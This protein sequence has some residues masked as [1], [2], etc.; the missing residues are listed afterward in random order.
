MPTH[1]TIVA[2]ISA[3]NEEDIIGQVVRALIADGVQVYFIDH[4][5]TDRTLDEVSPYRGRGVIGIERFP[6]DHDGKDQEMIG[7]FA[8]EDILR[9]KETLARELNADWFI[10]HDADEFRESPWPGLSLTEAIH[11]LTQQPAERIGLRNRGVLRAGAHADV[12][13]FDPLAFREEGT[14]FDPSRLATGMD[15]VIVN[16][17]VTLRGGELTG[18]RNGQVLRRV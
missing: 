9:R 11:R 15:T 12:I 1:P 2:I 6:Q 10:H 18:A 13:V 14:T 16:G 4:L 3:Y 7:A 8:W 17:A 5:S